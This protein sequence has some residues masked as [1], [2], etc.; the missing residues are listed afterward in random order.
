MQWSWS[1]NGV[2]TN[3]RYIVFSWLR[4]TTVSQLFEHAL[5]EVKIACFMRY[6]CVLASEESL[7]QLVCC[8]SVLILK[9]KWVR[10]AM[11]YLWDN[12]V[13][14]LVDNYHNKSDGLACKLRQP[15]CRPG[16]SSIDYERMLIESQELC[17]CVSVW[18]CLLICKC[19]C[20]C[21]HACVCVCVVCV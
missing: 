6:L 1:L 12:A 8:L 5:P 14:Q 9:L 11:R 10:I 7:L 2:L 3:M 21:L 19:V 20:V 13:F 17:V 18:V 15:C 4:T 16:Y